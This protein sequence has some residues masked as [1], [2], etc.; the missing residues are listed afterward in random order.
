[1]CECLISRE[2]GKRASLWRQS[3]LKGTRER[4]AGGKKGEARAQAE[5]VVEGAAE[6][7][8]ERRVGRARHVEHRQGA[9]V[10]AELRHQSRVAEERGGAREPRVARQVA[11]IAGHRECTQPR[12]REL[13]RALFSLAE[14]G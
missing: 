4:E 14:E 9:L 13:F 10:G 12:V 11:A 3:A 5:E 8:G 7:R 1:M 6:R 2:D